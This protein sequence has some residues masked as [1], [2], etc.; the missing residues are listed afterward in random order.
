MESVRLEKTNA[1]MCG[2]QVSDAFK[3]CHRSSFLTSCILVMASCTIQ[4][5]CS[6]SHKTQDRGKKNTSSINA[7]KKWNIIFQKCCPPSH[8]ADTHTCTLFCSLYLYISLS[9]FL[10]DVHFL[11]ESGSSEKF[12]YEKLNPEGSEKGNC[13]EDGDKWIQC[14]KQ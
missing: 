12:C 14:G 3:I 8:K 2:A 10:F 13:G 9:H 7:S 5:V 11:V 1:N 6:Y 4:N